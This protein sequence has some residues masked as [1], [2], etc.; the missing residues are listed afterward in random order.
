MVISSCS[1]AAVPLGTTHPAAPSAPTG[2]LAPPPPAL[3]PGVAGDVL[4]LPG[5]RAP[6]P[7]ASKDDGMKMH[8][9]GDSTAPKAKP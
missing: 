7:E 9:H 2:R 4:S 5:P 8:M 3:E 6:T 1:P